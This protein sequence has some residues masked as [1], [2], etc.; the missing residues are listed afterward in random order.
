MNYFISDSLGRPRGKA[1]GYSTLIDAMTALREDVDAD[2]I[3]HPDEYPFVIT[4]AAGEVQL[5][6]R[7]PNVQEG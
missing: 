5:T 2:S 1:A 3:N 4:N 6:E 7:L